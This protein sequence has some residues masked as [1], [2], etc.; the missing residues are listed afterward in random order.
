[1]ASITRAANGTWRVLFVGVKGRKPIYLGKVSRKAAESICTRVEAIVAA[2]FQGVALDTETAA[3]LGSRPDTFYAKLANVGLVSPR[4][5]KPEA[6]A[7]TLNAWLQSYIAS[8]PGMKPN[9]LKNYRATVKSLT[10]FFG[11]D[12]P[13]ATITPGDADEWHAKQVGLEFAPATIGR[14]VKRAKQFFRAAERKKLIA[15]NPFVDLKAPAQVN[16]TREFF[17]TREA[18]DKIIAEC[19]DAEW[20]LIVALARYGGVRTP[21]ETQALR[22]GDVD[23][24]GGRIRVR[25]PKT[26][27]HPGGESRMVPLYPELRP[28]LEAAFD[29]APEGAEH[30]ISKHRIGSGNLSTGLRRIMERAGVAPWPRLF[31]NMRASRETELTREHPLHVV[32][33]WIGNSAPI[34]ARH[35]LQVTDADFQRA[36]KAPVSG[37]D[38]S[39]EN[40]ALAAHQ[41]AQNAAQPTAANPR[42][43]H[44]ETHKAQQKPGL[45]LGLATVGDYW[46][47]ENV[48]PRGVE[49]LFSD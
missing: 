36:S 27:H 39:A 48:P 23:W 15:E 2:Q 10:E 41:A 34:A 8:K 14:N 16:K 28:H 30:C 4:D 24:A 9:T 35:Y 18:T 6:P 12:R 25:S 49:P 17:V 21:S 44:Q 20:R 19:P 29:A 13:L 33:A 42:Q 11:S 32:T 37:P 40:S 22:W 46:P 7:V 38:R 5:V 3:W 1:M 31:Q 45:G 43:S 26:A 47:N